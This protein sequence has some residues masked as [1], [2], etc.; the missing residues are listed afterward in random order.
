MARRSKAGRAR[1]EQLHLPLEETDIRQNKKALG[2]YRD[3][4]AHHAIVYKIGKTKISFVEMKKGKL[5]TH[6]LTDRKFLDERC[7]ERVEYPLERAVEN[8]LQHGGG[9]SEAARRAL[10]TVLQ[11]AQQ[12]GRVP[13]PLFS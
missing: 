1:L 6:T 5:V 12:E 11:E 8:F 13:L 2:V 3:H 9:V 7:F 10:L 4:N